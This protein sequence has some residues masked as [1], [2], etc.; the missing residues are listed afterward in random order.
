MDAIVVDPA[1]Y[2]LDTESLASAL[3]VSERAAELELVLRLADEAKRHAWPRA[4]YSIAYIEDRGDD[5]VAAAGGRLSSR[6]LRVN[7]DDLH[8]FFPYVVTSGHELEDWATASGDMLVR[9]Y[10]DAISQAVLLSALDGL[11]ER[12]CRTYDLAEL[13]AMHP[14]SLG[15]WPL[16]EQRVLFGLLGDVTGA[17]GVELTDSLLMRPTKS[18]SGIFFPAEETFDSCRL[19]P[20]EP[21]SNRRAPY[22]A[23]LFERRFAGA[24]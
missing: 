15:D 23:G 10:A 9:F 17:I 11:R 20:R 18:V 13:S 14:G 19:C 7:L 22:D 21:C 12:L 2:R 3:R 16:E 5:F 4:V 24:G 1:P 8:R 6:V